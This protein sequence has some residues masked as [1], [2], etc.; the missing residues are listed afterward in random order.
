[1]TRNC[2]EEAT[3]ASRKAYRDHVVGRR[4]AKAADATAGCIGKKPESDRLNEFG[5]AHMHGS[6]F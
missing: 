4:P 3:R 2:V 1:M 6:S 5:A